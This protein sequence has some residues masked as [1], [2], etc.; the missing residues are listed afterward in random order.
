MDIKKNNNNKK[1]P[2]AF[3][4]ST[5]YTDVIMYSVPKVS[6]LNGNKTISY[7]WNMYFYCIGNLSRKELLIMY[8]LSYI[9][10]S[11]LR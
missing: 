3:K 7:F 1:H 8:D 4:I 11:I 6:I 9:Y 10:L 5:I 2:I